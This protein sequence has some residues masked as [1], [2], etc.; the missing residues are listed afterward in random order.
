MKFVKN[1]S[2]GFYLGILTIIAAIVGMYFYFVNSATAT[3]G[4]IPLNA[5]TVYGGVLAIVLELFVLIAGQFK[6]NNGWLGVLTDISC[7]AIA[8]LLV[9]GATVFF[10]DRIN[11]FAGVM[12]FNRNA[13]TLAD[14]SSALIGI[15]ALFGSGALA[16][17]ASFFRVS[18]TTR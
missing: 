17:V 11:L 3:F 13:Q 5:V 2:F 4:N 12:T 6:A 1:Q 16:I 14:M 7:V 8:V 15:A 18:K 9:W 10:A